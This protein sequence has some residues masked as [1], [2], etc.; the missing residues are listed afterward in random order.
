ME[1]WTEQEEEEYQKLA[2]KNGC[3]VYWF[4]IICSLFGIFL[5]K[6]FVVNGGEAA[7]LPVGFVFLVMGLYS[8][9]SY[10]A[11]ER[12]YQKRNRVRKK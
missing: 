7:L 11:F 4:G 9:S 10:P 5:M 8:L 3:G 2:G 12:L 1:E 6:E